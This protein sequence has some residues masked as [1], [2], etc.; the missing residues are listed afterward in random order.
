MNKS[1][2]LSIKGTYYYGAKVLHD[3]GRLKAGANVRLVHE[4]NNPH[5]KNAVAIYEA[6]SGEKL[7]HVGREHA[8]KYAILADKSKIASA[9]I[10]EVQKDKNGRLRIYVLVSYQDQASGEGGIDLNRFNA[11]PSESGIYAIRCADNEKEYVGSSG[12]VRERVKTHFKGLFEGKHPNN[13]L[14]DDFRRYGANKFHAYMDSYCSLGSL[15]D[16]EQEAILIRLNSH[17]GL[18]N[19]TADGQGYYSDGPRGGATSSIS[20]KK[21]RADRTSRPYIANEVRPLTKNTG[22]LPVIAIFVIGV[23]MFAF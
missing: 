23:L 3:S 10:S 18:Y 2:T 5:D 1:V 16:K 14:Q 17:K 12:N 11:L 8:E 7:G 15:A 19:L 13:L 21:A 20:D 6:V 22:C 9:R 4:P